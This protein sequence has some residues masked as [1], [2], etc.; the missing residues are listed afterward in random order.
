MDAY[1]Y[2]W[3]LWF[4]SFKP[5]FWSLC[6]SNPVLTYFIVSF[7]SK[8][9]QK[10]PTTL[11]LDQ[12]LLIWYVEIQSKNGWILVISQ[13]LAKISHN[14]LY[15]SQSIGL[16]LINFFFPERYMPWAHLMFS[17]VNSNVKYMFT[18]KFQVTRVSDLR[19]SPKLKIHFSRLPVGRFSIRF[20]RC[21]P[22][23]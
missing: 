5:V 19:I 6:L 2:L 18:V 22:L 17:K 12:Y 4:G 20:L 21:D 3:N 15:Y 7:T 16:I 8:T 10:D 14:S 1:W 23:S 11:Y 9:F 13:I